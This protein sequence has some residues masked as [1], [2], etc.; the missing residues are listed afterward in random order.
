MPTAE[1]SDDAARRIAVEAFEHALRRERHTVSRRPQLLWQ[2]LHNR[3]RWE[4]PAPEAL[5]SERERRSR[6]GSAPWVRLDAPLPESEELIGTLVGHTGG[7]Q[8][9]A[10]SPDGRRLVSASV[11]T[12]KVW[13]A[14]SGAELRTLPSGTHG[15]YAC[16]FSPDG[17]QIVSAGNDHTVRVWDAES[18]GRLYTLK[19]HTEPV[20]ACAF[21]PDGSLIVSASGT[22]EVWN[23]ESEYVPRWEA[24]DTPVRGASHDPRYVVSGS[25]TLRLWHTESRAEKRVLGDVGDGRHD[26]L[27]LLHERLRAIHDSRAPDVVKRARRRR[28]AR[29]H[30]G[31]VWACAFSPDGTTIVVAS[32]DGTL[33]VWDVRRL[34]PRR[35][36]ALKGHAG[37]V[38]ACAFSPDGSLIVS[39]ST[40]TTL[41][42]WDA[43]T[44]QGVRTLAAHTGAVRACAFSPD[45]RRIASAGDD[46]TLKVWDAESGAEIRTLEGHGAGVHACAFSPDGRRIVSA[47]DDATLKVWD[48]EWRSR[49]RAARPPHRHAAM[50]HACAFSPDGR[51]IVSA[52]EDGTLKVWD[53]ES[54][55]EVRTLEG[56]GKPILACTFSPDGERI[57]SASA[58]GT[59]R[60]WA[61]GSASGAG[62]TV[63]RG[64]AGPVS[65]CAFSPDGH[66]IVSANYDGTLTGWD[67]DGE[68]EVFTLGAEI[69]ALEG[70][71][72]A[73]DAGA[74]AVR[75]CAFSPDG[76]QIVSAT[77]DVYFKV[78]GAAGG[79]GRNLGGHVGPSPGRQALFGVSQGG[80]AQ[81]CAFTPDG[82]YVAYG[83]TKGALVAWD[84]QSG[85]EIRALIGR[86]GGLRDWA[87]SP[88]GRWVI[89]VEDDQTLKIWDAG[90]AGV[91]AVLPFPS[92]LRVIC[93]HPWLPRVACGDAGGRIHRMELVAIEYGPIIVTAAHRG[94]GLAI[95]CPACRHEHFVEA[96]QLD[97]EIACA[98][99]G[100]GLRLRINPF[101]I[102]A[103]G[104]ASRPVPSPEPLRLEQALARQ[105]PYA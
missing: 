26:P 20:Q 15:V 37:M 44:G 42:V 8:A 45:G 103:S 105:D 46:A 5:D 101:V 80:V 51:S 13:D 70:Y 3:L 97:S 29:H 60:L 75:A 34:T 53:A 7:V 88:D 57:C 84:P 35:V 9:C 47:S 62:L 54:G 14:E 38:H 49:R 89:S 99:Q 40:D 25:G 21:S 63:L 59:V 64:D 69:R 87:F 58:D 95:R 31:G 76:R 61:L 1:A 71:A 16:A 104:W 18:G 10:F 92:A 2:Q 33:R 102:E 30:G 48:P 77:N 74:L 78:W 27:E 52:G 68:A 83:G 86:A 17:A 41:K 85:D 98:T 12:I 23:P 90:S 19:G 91:A 36:R 82:R 79:R 56:H 93:I 73:A 66:W 4:H 67:A 39:A 50:V 100:C 6:P 72:R 65:D 32:T 55:G 43:L 11:R 94:R 24:D 22:L 28:L 96:D 81:R